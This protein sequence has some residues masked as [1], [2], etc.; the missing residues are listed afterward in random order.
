MNPTTTSATPS[1][2]ARLERLGRFLEMDP[3]NALLLR[4]YAF[5]AAQAGELD[6]AIVALR[7]L[8]AQPAYEPGD[9]RLL[10]ACL[11]A[12]RRND[13]AQAVLA[14]ARMRWPGDE[15]L[16]I[17]QAKACFAD[18]D[19]EAA[20]TA[21]PPDPQDPMLAGE[22]CSL[23][24]QLLHHLD[25]LEE[26]AELAQTFSASHPEDPRVPASF[27]PVLMDTYRFDEA[28][29]LARELL[30]AGIEAYPVYEALAAG[31]LEAGAP[32]EASQWTARALK[33]R[34]DDGRIWLLEG[35][36]RMRGGQP[37]EAALALDE[38]VTLMP[39]H[40]GSQ[41]ALGWLQLLQKDQARAQACFE[42]AVAASPAFAESH[43]SLAVLAV[44]Q[45]RREDAL[46]LIRKAQRLDSTCAS[47]Q[48]AKALLAGADP[49]G[50]AR[51]AETMLSQVR[52][53][54]RHPSN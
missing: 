49:A 7:R 20:L 13:E 21:L 6:A 22:A 4:D 54:R 36:A 53:A 39:D 43:G 18:R 3:G 38:A 25:R 16:A 10:G 11:R 35:L 45:G 2:T 12:A 23:R 52:A 51:L 44:L 14:D 32:A 30:D 24:V 33:V 9:T 48:Y 27:I 47:A 29:T 26:A 50:I 17:E 8:L 31:A 42:A 1:R 19:F 28:V 34:R 41:L 37:E 46:E 15:A 40:A 5:E